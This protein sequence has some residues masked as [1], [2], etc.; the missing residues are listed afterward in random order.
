MGLSSRSCELS[1]NEEEG[2]V[3]LAYEGDMQ[4]VYGD[5][6]FVHVSLVGVLMNLI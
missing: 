2:K 5:K 6:K 3:V 1:M 4:I